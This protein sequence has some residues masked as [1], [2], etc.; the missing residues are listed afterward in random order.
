M[1]K[2]DARS[3][4]RDGR[5]GRAVR[6]K[7]RLGA[8]ASGVFDLR[9]R[10]ADGLRQRLNFWGEHSFVDRSAGHERVLVLL[11]GYKPY[12]WQFTLKRIER[13]LEDGIDV[14]V[15]SPGMHS[16]HLDDVA[17]ANEWSLLTTK[18]NSVSLGQNL[19][20]AKH[21]R[22][23]YVY[24]LDEDVFVARGFFGDL[25]RGLIAVKEEG[26]YSPGFCAPVLNV[27]GYSYVNFLE[28][29]SLTEDYQRCFGELRRAGGGVRA[30]YDGKAAAWLWSK[31]LPL[32]E[33]AERFSSREFA[34]SVVPHHFNIGALVYERDL[35]EAMG[36]F[37]VTLP[38]GIIGGDEKNI[39]MKCVELSRVMVVAHNVFVGHFA[40][41][42]QEEMMRE[43]LPSLEPGLAL[44]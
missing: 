1:T 24:K 20:I 6:S 30:H 39:C 29:M 14:C 5:Q 22:A 7:V 23:R 37:K 11:A 32:D 2:T 8:L 31:S 43:S 10:S 13:F 27:N 42:P 17:R 44:A 21:P 38:Y 26:S 16:Q 15:V 40:F 19:A 28:T 9:R 25:L 35:W 34:Y 3:S 12:L 33:V 4:L 18:A 41:G 36:G